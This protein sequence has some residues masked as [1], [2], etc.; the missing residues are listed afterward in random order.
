M[1]LTMHVAEHRSHPRIH[2]HLSGSIREMD[3]AKVSETLG[4]LRRKN[5]SVVLHNVSLGGA[6]LETDKS[7]DR[8]HILRLEFSLPTHGVLATFAEVCWVNADKVGVR[9]LALPEKGSSSLRQFVLR[10]NIGA[11]RDHVERAKA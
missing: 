10:E 3:S 8:G 11:Y 4:D 6:C 9:F 2:C 7:V 1:T 5:S